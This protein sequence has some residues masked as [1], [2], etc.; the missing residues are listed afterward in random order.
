[1]QTLTTDVGSKMLYHWKPSSCFRAN[2]SICANIN[3]PL[4]M[5]PPRHPLPRCL[6]LEQTLVFVQ[7]LIFLFTSNFLDILSLVAL[8]TFLLIC[9]EA[10]QRTLELGAKIVQRILPTRVMPAKDYASKDAQTVESLPL[11]NYGPFR[12]PNW[13]FPLLSTC[14]QGIGTTHVPLYFKLH[15]TM[16]IRM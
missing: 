4:H 9:L 7:T 14:I 15:L 1:M 10:T 8:D 16:S 6:A 2:I 3:L 12:A 11:G 13:S 5:K